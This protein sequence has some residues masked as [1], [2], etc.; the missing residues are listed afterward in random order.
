MPN[1]SHDHTISA[2]P[3]V[4]V[5][6]RRDNDTDEFRIDQGVDYIYLD[7]RAAEELQTTLDI[8]L[9][10]TEEPCDLCHLAELDAAGIAVEVWTDTYA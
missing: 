5:R 4:N 2:G 6:V 1:Y 8:F 7:R 10:E 9:T 3:F